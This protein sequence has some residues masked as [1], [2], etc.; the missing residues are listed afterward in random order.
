MRGRLHFAKAAIAFSLALGVSLGLS[1]QGCFSPPQPLCVF[2]CG[3]MGECPGDYECHEGYCR[4]TGTSG[5]CPFPRDAAVPDGPAAD[6]PGG[7][8]LVGGGD[9]TSTDDLTGT[10]DG[11]D[12]DLT[13][14]DDLTSTD[15]LTAPP[16]DLTLVLP[17]DLII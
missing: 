6:L 10:G 9:L 1:V 2:R 12:N 8:D 15:D 17:I 11:G 14:S 13:S 3:P 5:L 7:A 16:D 4:R